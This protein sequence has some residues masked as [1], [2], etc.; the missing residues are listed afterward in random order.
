MQQPFY[1]KICCM[2]KIILLF[3]GIAILLAS[4]T[5]APKKKIT[6]YLIG[7]STMCN[8]EPSR[9]PLTGWGMP[10][11]NFFDSTVKI[12]NRA[13]GGRS[14][15]TFLGE[16]RWQPIADSLQEGDMYWYSL[17]IMMKPKKKNIR[18][19]IHP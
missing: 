18:I 9:A 10:F 12:D 13:R 8:Y 6:V 17:G 7:D 1:F 4:F 11:A 3:S 14:T 15:R 16:G 19:G 5:D 2:K